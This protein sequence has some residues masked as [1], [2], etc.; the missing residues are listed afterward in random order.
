[1]EVVGQEIVEQVNGR[2]KKMIKTDTGY[3]TGKYFDTRKDAIEALLVVLA[4]RQVTQLQKLQAE[5]KE[6]DS[7]EKTINHWK[8]QL[9]KGE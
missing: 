9:N 5:Q 2:N 3:Y 8:E 6:F 1:M 7:I 4:K